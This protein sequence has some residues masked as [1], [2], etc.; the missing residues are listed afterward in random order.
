M[1]YIIFDL[2]ATCW[3]TVSDKPGHQEIIEIGAVLPDGEHFQPMA[4]YEQFV[5][6][7]RKT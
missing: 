5:R 4:E 7:L 1:N 2:E 3:E 6:H